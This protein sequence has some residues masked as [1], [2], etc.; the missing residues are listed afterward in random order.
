MF[1]RKFLARVSVVICLGLSAIGQERRD[2]R[3]GPSIGTTIESWRALDQSG[4]ERRVKDLLGPS[5]ALL[6]VLRSAEW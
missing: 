3:P 4:T 5:G 1:G 2:D 6:P